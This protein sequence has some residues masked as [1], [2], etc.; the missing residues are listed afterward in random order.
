MP[1]QATACC[2]NA[3]SSKAGKKKRAWKDYEGMPSNVLNNG[4]KCAEEDEPPLKRRCD[5]NPG[6]EDGQLGETKKMGTLTN[7]EAIDGMQN[8]GDFWSDA[9]HLQP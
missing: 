9:T 1:P 7:L 5:E 4:F 3:G 2:I 8:T 6:K